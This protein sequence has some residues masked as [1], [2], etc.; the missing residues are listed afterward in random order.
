M[1]L[2]GFSS[3]GKR[4]AGKWTDNNPANGQ[5]IIKEIFKE[6][7]KF[8]E[9]PD[10]FPKGAAAGPGPG[11]V[12]RLKMAE[13]LAIVWNSCRKKLSLIFEEVISNDDVFRIY[14]GGD[15]VA[16]DE[17]LLKEHKI[18]CVVNCTL[19]FPNN[20]Q[21]KGMSYHRVPILDVKGENLLT[22]LPDAI[23]F[24]KLA[25]SKG[26]T[27]LIHCMWGMSR[28]P[29]VAIAYF[30]KEKQM[31]LAGSLKKIAGTRSCVRP[32]PSFVRQLL[33]WEKQQLI[34]SSHSEVTTDVKAG[35][36]DLEQYKA[37]Y[38]LTK[39]TLQHDNSDDGHTHRSGISTQHNEMPSIV[40]NLE[41]VTSLLD[42]ADADDDSCGAS[43]M[44]G[45]W[46]ACVS[47]STLL[48][49]RR[50]SRDPRVAEVRRRLSPPPRPGSGS[51]RRCHRALETSR[52]RATFTPPH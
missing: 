29:A 27:V 35:S 26:S 12:A 30:I 39:M 34:N 25:R 42:E 15:A 8:L 46:R 36:V 47:G 4:L 31:T 50:I 1:P 38:E 22:H 44:D 49:V 37:A 48:R 20:F 14:L 45:G 18:T 16:E 51:F 6:W 24:I 17:T 41:T 52:R 7:V 32:N 10:N 21:D 9:N 40:G 19:G 28:A 2:P 11:G 43:A 5:T 33:E 13:N 23:D 3:R